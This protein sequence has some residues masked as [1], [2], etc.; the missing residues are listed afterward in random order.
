MTTFLFWNINRKPLENLLRL[1]VGAHAPHIIILAECR[2]TVDDLLVTL[3]NGGAYTYRLLRDRLAVQGPSRLVLVSRL[4]RSYVRPVAGIPEVAIYKVKPLEGEELLL[5]AM[6]LPSKLYHDATAQAL[7]ATRLPSLIAAAERSAKHQRTV[8]IGDLNMDP[9]EAGITSSETLH[10][11]MDRQVALR[12]TRQVQGQRRSLFYNPMWSRLG[13]GTSG[14]PG[15]YYMAASGPLTNYWYTLDQV[16]IRPDLLA[17]FRDEN[18]T[19]LTQV[20]Q[21]NL[22]SPTGI[23]NASVASDHLPLLFK[24]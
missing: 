13:D 10:A 22:L 18:L 16:L 11:V 12:E 15:T 9:F 7:L 24:I 17:N 5:V 1:L 20:G 4:P 3:N 6:H 8:V 19:V 21:I 14:P 2:I 23:P